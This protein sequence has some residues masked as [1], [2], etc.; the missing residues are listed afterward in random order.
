MFESIDEFLTL[1]HKAEVIFSLEHSQ[2]FKVYWE[3][4]NS[5]LPNYLFHKPEPKAEH[6]IV[7]TATQVPVEEEEIVNVEQDDR[8]IQNW[9]EFEK[10]LS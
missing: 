10:A 3:Q 6:I 7:A 5:H 8:F 1:Q 9:E 4:W 2:R